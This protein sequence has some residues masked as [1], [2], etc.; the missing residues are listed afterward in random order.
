VSSYTEREDFT[1]AVLV[2]SS[3]G[4]PDGERTTVLANRGG[5]EPDGFVT[6][7]DLQACLAVRSA[8]G[9]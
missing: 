2:V 6:L 3:L 4:D 1:E 9:S 5:A 7:A 8:H